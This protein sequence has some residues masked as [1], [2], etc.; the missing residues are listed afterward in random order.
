MCVFFL[1]DIGVRRPSPHS[2]SLPS[3]PVPLLNVFHKS[4]GPAAWLHSSYFLSPTLTFIPPW[5][6][7][8]SHFSWICECS[9]SLK[10]GLFPPIL[11]FILVCSELGQT[12]VHS[13]ILDKDLSTQKRYSRI[14]IGISVTFLSFGWKPRRFQ[15]EIGPDLHKPWQILF[16]NEFV[17]VAWKCKKKKKLWKNLQNASN[18]VVFLSYQLWSKSLLVSSWKPM[19][20]K[21][22]IL[23]WMSNLI[24]NSHLYFYFSLTN[25]IIHFAP[26]K[27]THL[28]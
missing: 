20:K 14:Q 22:E 1:G 24:I 18:C 10:S 27:I 9:V 21:S 25:L 12:V 7:S 3:F 6:Q 16:L 19:E 5:F 17:F 26:F 4:L 13:R 11:Y 23:N 8:Q 28:D 2:P 15:W